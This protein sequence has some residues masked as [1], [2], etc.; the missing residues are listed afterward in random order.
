MLADGRLHLSGIA[1]LAP[2]LTR[3]NG[4]ALLDPA[5][6]KTKRQIEELL[7]EISPRPDVPPVVRKLPERTAVSRLGP[8]G[9]AMTMPA[10]AGIG[11]AAF[12]LEE[13]RDTVRTDELRPDRVAS[14]NT[15]ASIQ[16]LSP[17]RYRVQFTA[18][19]ELREKL[20]RLRA[21]M[22]SEV[23]DGDLGAIL[24]RAVTEK[25]D[26]LEA[27]RIGKTEAPRKTLG[28]TDTSRT[29]RQIPAAVRRAVWKRD[30]GRCRF[31]DARGRR[32]SER[33][34]LEFHHRHPFA[35]GGDH[36]VDNICLMCL[37]HNRYLAEH[38]YGRK[39]MSRF[40]ARTERAATAV[41]SD[42]PPVT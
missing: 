5:A 4:E 28:Q 11:S 29:S 3:E 1:K 40:G 33:H 42:G 27:R 9:V 21:L 19:G 20:E 31:V 23:P 22:R 14:S 26:R 10:S 16:P 6:H 30:G 7:A 15:S 36:R 34:R 8:D 41:R 12:D 35:H 17:S 37:A 32:C 2:R 24:E 25:L 13:P 18:S 39:V 38:D